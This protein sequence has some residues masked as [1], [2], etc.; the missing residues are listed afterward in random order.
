MLRKLHTL[1]VK[2]LDAN[3]IDWNLQK[4][5]SIGEKLPPLGQREKVV[6]N[7]SLTIIA[8]GRCIS[9]NN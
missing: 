4:K 7:S 3:P 5:F 9:K 1:F 8:V 2:D 6:N